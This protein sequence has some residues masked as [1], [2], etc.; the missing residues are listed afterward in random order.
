M[1]EGFFWRAPTCR[2]RSRHKF[3]LNTCSGCHAGETGTDFTHVAPRAA[4]QASVLSP[5][6][7]GGTVT[8]PVT[9]M[10]RSFDDLGRRA[11]DLAALVCGTPS[12]DLTGVETFGGFPVPSNLPPAR[13]H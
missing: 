7:R 9:Q 5:F 13:V 11:A 4:G 12:Q 6:L 8:D 1:P 10:P 3:S 2:R